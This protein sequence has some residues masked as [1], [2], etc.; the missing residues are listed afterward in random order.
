MRKLLG[1]MLALAAGALAGFFIVFNSVFSDS[2][3]SSGERIFT[4]VLVAAAYGIIGFASGMLVP[5]QS[6]LLSILACL[7]A[8]VILLWYTAREHGI[9]IYSVTYLLLAFLSVYFAAH[10]TGTTKHKRR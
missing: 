7:P 2:S 8:A 4:Y 6:M 10:L 9:A 5:R 3:G 1:Y